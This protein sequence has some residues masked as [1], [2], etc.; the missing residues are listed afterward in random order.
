MIQRLLVPV[1]GSELSARAM[2]ESIRLAQ[3]LGVGITGFVAEP[4]SMAS[5]SVSM[6]P[7]HRKIAVGVHKARTAEH[8]QG[9]LGRFEAQARE[10]GIDFDGHFTHVSDVD[11]A[12]V[13]AAEQHGCDMIVIAMHERG[14]IDGLLSHSHTKGVIA[15]SRVPVVV[16]H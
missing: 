4:Q 12:I 2:E 1:D 13:Q 15:R 9:V 11:E 8:A 6:M 5:L 16:V 10:A 14:V 7:E 3:Q